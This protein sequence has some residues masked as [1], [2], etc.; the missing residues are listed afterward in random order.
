MKTKIHFPAGGSLTT[1]A[2]PTSAKFTEHFAFW[3][4]YNPSSGED[5]TMEIYPQSFEFMQMVEE[6]RTLRIYRTKE[7][8]LTVNSGYRTQAFNDSLPGSVPWSG[9]TK[10]LSIDIACMNLSDKELMQEVEDWRRTC[11]EYHTVGEC[12]LGKGYI[13]LGAFVECYSN[14]YTDKFYFEDKR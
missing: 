1:S 5:I 10:M 11:D 6:W 7:E 2:I 8:G 13:H 9:H 12:I 4:L 14:P 3:E